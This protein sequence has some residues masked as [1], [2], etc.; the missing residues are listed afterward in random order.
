MDVKG[1]IEATI[2]DAIG[3]EHIAMEL[4][5]PPTLPRYS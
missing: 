2:I 5:N 4:N 1:A 3:V